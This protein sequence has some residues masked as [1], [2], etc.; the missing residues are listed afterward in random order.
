M[1]AV[2]ALAVAHFCH[3][4]ASDP[5]KSEIGKFF[6]LNGDEND[7]NEWLKLAIFRFMGCRRRRGC[8]SYLSTT[9]TFVAAAAARRIGASVKSSSP[10]VCDTNSAKDENGN[11]EISPISPKLL[12]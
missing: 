5:V 12:R 1:A 4:T 7:E 6:H 3:K 11:R 8:G 10:N 9:T 2:A